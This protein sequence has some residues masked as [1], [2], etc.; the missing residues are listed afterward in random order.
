MKYKFSEK[1]R[2]NPKILRNQPA[3]TVFGL[4]NELDVNQEDR[5]YYIVLMR[6]GHREYYNLA[7]GN[8]RPLGD[9]CP[10]IVMDCALTFYGIKD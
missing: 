4:Y 10:V 3:G 6:N 7:D 9:T 2:P 5:D 8:F 1:D